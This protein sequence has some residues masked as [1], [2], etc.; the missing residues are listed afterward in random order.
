M[1]VLA[2]L[3]HNPWNAAF[4]WAFKRHTN[5]SIPEHREEWSGLASS[6]KE[7][8]DTAIDLL[9][10]RLRKLQAGSENVR[11]V[12]V[13]EARNDIDRARKALLERNLPSAMRAMARAEKELILADPDTR[14]D[15]DKMEEN[16]EEIPYI[17]LTGEE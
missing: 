10:D 7:E 16:D 3:G 4:G 6:G 17:D 15:I 5:L 9:E 14:S 11:K 13:E 12:H 1:D 8:M 2:S